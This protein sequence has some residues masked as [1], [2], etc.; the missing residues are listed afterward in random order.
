MA[1]TR[2]DWDDLP[3]QTRAAVEKHTGTVLDARTVAEG[4]N[5]A[6]AL[7]LSTDTGDVFV[8][9]LR[10]DYPRQ[11]TQDMEWMIG[12]HL[13]GVAPRTL[14]RTEDD[15]E[16]DLLG[17]EAVASRHATY[18]PGSSDLAL[19]LTT[20]R[21][22]GTIACPQV[23]MKTAENRWKPYMATPDDAGLLV[24]DR[25]LH[26]DYNPL[27]VLI[28]E[29]GRGALLIDWAWPTRGAGWID[30]AC[31]IVRLIADGHTA[32]QAEHVVASL[33]AWQGAPAEA[34]NAFADASTRLW[35]EIADRDPVSWTGRMAEAAHEWA[36]HRRT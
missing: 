8:K 26:T 13:G 15:P 30:P 18:Q 28:A 36:D 23:P 35:Q 25:L 10:R 21:I 27:N 31:L 7:L 4:L 12:K 16:W 20:M 24:G 22:L 3:E 2:I 33:P 29:D 32:R 11:W 14:W 9:G 17:F 5:S 6:V 1:L 19:L 34:V